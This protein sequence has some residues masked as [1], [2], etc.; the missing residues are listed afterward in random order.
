MAVKKTI[1][2]EAKTSGAEANIEGLKDEIQSLNQAT[3]NASSAQNQMSKNTSD[4]TEEV[5]KNGGAMAILNQ[6]TGGLAQQ[7]KDSYEAVQLSTKGLSGFKKA[8][9]ATGIGIT[10]VAV[11]ALAAN[12]EK[13]TMFLSGTTE[14]QKKYNEAVD[15]GVKSANAASQSLRTLRDIALDETASTEAREQALSELSETVKDLNDVTLDQEDALQRIT[16]ATDP[17]IKAVE[18]RAKAEAFA[19]IIAEEEA[20]IL[21]QRTELLESQA[22]ADATKDVELFGALTQ[23]AV[24]EGNEAIQEQQEFVDTLTNEYRSLLSTALEFE[25]QNEET[26][27]KAEERTQNAKERQ[28]QAERDADQA[29]KDLEALQAKVAEIEEENKNRRLSNE[30]IEKNA[31]LD[32]YNTI[33][34]AAN[35]AGI[36][37]VLIEAEKQAQI[38]EIED[39]YA[40]IRKDEAD[41]ATE[42]ANQDAADE[43]ARDKAVQDAKI[44]M[45]KSTLGNIS[46]AVGENTKAGKAAAAA[47]AL[48]N[49]YQGISAEL[50]TKTVTPFGFALKLANIAT[51]AAI[52]FKSVKDILKTNPETAGGGTAAPSATGRAAQAEPIPPAFN[53]VGASGANQLAEAIGGQTQQPV[54]AFVVSNDVSTAQELDRNIV[55]G[56]SIG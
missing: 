50:A 54:K 28:T 55:E 43:I 35:K 3:V 44:A 24:N 25:N 42:K 51:T 45:A 39:R 40:Q 48:I 14:E 5:T 2:I 49:T 33:I 52:G 27:K 11:G 38:K 9:L 37:T 12:W 16:E 41:A 13:V 26:E 4:L 32:K 22:I 20:K 29:V 15:E 18:A 23:A 53:I 7:F 30:Q 8:M 1:I 19:K 46:K 56:A 34:E 36:D 47:A 17:Y 10:V 21:K 6:L 31:V